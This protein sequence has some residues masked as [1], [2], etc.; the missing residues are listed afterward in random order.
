MEKVGIGVG[1]V[2]PGLSKNPPRGKKNKSKKFISS[3]GLG[4]YTDYTPTLFQSFLY[5]NRENRIS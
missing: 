5:S 3:V 1:G 2:D 4:V